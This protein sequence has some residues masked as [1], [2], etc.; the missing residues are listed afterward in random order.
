MLSSQWPSIEVK[1]AF[2]ILLMFVEFFIPFTILIF[3]YVKIVCVLS[4]RIN[5][6]LIQNTSKG[7]SS[8]ITTGQND[9]NKAIDTGRDKFLIARRNTI[10]TL[11]IIGACF[12]ICWSQN[13]ILYFMYN[14]GYNLDYNSTYFNYTIIMVFLNCTV[15]PFIYVLKYRDYQ[16]ALKNFFN[17]TKN[18]PDSSIGIISFSMSNANTPQLLS[19]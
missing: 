2:G 5:T 13:Q 16:E 4:R 1:T 19:T 9:R 12:I 8:E 15:N 11:L 14:C 3:C 17:C 7:K 18:E 10:T 6:D